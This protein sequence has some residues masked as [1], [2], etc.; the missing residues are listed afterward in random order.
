LSPSASTVALPDQFHALQAERL[1]RYRKRPE[2]AMSG[3][4]A[5]LPPT[6][7]ACSICSTDTARCAPRHRASTT[8]WCAAKETRKGD[9]FQITTLPRPSK[10]VRYA[11][12]TRSHAREPIRYIAQAS[13]FD[14]PSQFKWTTPHWR[15]APRRASPPQH[16]TS[17][18]H[19]P[20]S[21][22]VHSHL[23]VR[24]SPFDMANA[25]DSAPDSGTQTDM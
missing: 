19:H 1:T 17:A 10:P 6:R 8:L 14:R 7:Q 5:K 15:F 3:V 24:A 18:P 21:D 23:L 20:R 13:P 4:S 16:A 2:N 9:T 11:V 25:I 22:T 12:A